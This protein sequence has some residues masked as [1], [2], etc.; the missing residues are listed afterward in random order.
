M[1][2]YVINLDRHPQRM[3]RMEALLEGVD[4]VRVRAIDGASLEG[5]EVRGRGVPARF[6]AV[7]RYERACVASHAVA[8]R[9]LL[10]T[11]ASHACILEDDVV[12]SPD[13]LQWVSSS[14]WMSDDCDL[15][16]IETFQQGVFKE[17][18]RRA[19]RDRS[20]VRLLSAHHGAAG[21]VITR[22]GAQAMLAHAE[23]PA[24]PLDILL[25]EVPLAGAGLSMRQL[26]PALCM[27]MQHLPPQA[28]ALECQSSIQVRRALRQ[29]RGWLGAIWWELARP[30]RQ[31][32]EAL[33]HGVPVRAKRSAVAFR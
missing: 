16:K 4:F 3:A 14:H 32:K 11:E 20:V 2:T 24:R 15:M 29:R 5:P 27:Q 10:D 12:L 13:F 1:R 19:C 6:E 17:R 26:V 22:A 23:R 7:T 21:Y 28:Q 25:F 33:R 31:L 30:A 18:R 9:L 8:W